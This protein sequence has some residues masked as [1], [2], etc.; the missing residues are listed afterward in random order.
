M[1]NLFPLIFLLTSCYTET[2]PPDYKLMKSIHLQAA[3]DSSLKTTIELQPKKYF[4]GER[5]NIKTFTGSFV[6]KN[7]GP[8]PFKIAGIQSNCDCIFTR[9]D[10]NEI[11]PADSLKVSYEIDVRNSHGLIRNSIIAIG[12]CQF[13]NQT[14]YL[15][16]NISNN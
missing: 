10:K 15:E 5:R 1:K 9:Y 11:A 16:G 8:Q 12:N 3:L 4:F 2:Q 13:G 14:F 7:K 6:I